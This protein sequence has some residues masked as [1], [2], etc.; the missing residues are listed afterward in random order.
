MQNNCKVCQRFLR[1]DAEINII[2]LLCLRGMSR[3]SRT[4]TAVRYRAW[5]GMDMPSSGCLSRLLG[6]SY[7][8]L[9]T[10]FLF[11]CGKWKNRH[12]RVLSENLKW[13]LSSIQHQAG[14][15]L[16]QASSG[17]LDFQQ[18]VF[19]IVNQSGVCPQ[20]LPLTQE[21]ELLSLAV[22]EGFPLQKILPSSTC[23]TFLTMPHFTPTF[24]SCLSSSTYLLVQG[25]HRGGS[26]AEESLE[27]L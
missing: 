3:V 20:T 7:H 27:Q 22:G 6:Q 5:M 13:S 8:K 23:K 9:L 21:T 16:Y 4:F 2:L 1:A 12:H 25:C 18:P 11:L 14:R 24:L 15:F 17:Q 19:L 26:T 10:G